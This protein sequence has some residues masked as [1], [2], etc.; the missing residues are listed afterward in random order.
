MPDRIVGDDAR[1]T[2]DG[3]IDLDRVVWDPDY[4][5]KVLDELNRRSRMLT[6]DRS[7]RAPAAPKRE[8]EKPTVG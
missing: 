1:R 2:R 6:P 5:R 4:R 8:R 3:D 7:E